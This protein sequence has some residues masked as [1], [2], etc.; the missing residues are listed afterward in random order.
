MRD[1]SEGIRHEHLDSVF[2]FRA[3]LEMLL[4]LIRDPPMCFEK[5]CNRTKQDNPLIYQSK[6]LNVNSDPS[7]DTR[8]LPSCAKCKIAKY[9]CKEHQE[10]DWIR[11]HK[12]TCTHLSALKQLL[13]LEQRPF[14]GHINFRF[15]VQN[16]T[17]TE[18]QQKS[19]TATLDFMLHHSTLPLSTFALSTP[20]ERLLSFMNDK[21]DWVV[22]A[23]SSLGVMAPL[24]DTF[25]GTSFS[26]SVVGRQL[27]ESVVRAKLKCQHSITDMLPRYEDEGREPLWLNLL[28]EA[29]IALETYESTLAWLPVWS[30]EAACPIHWYMQVDC[31]EYYRNIYDASPGWTVLD[32]DGQLLVRHSSGVIA[33]LHDEAVIL[34]QYVKLS[35]AQFPLL[36]LSPHINRGEQTEEIVHGSKDTPHL[37]TVWLR[38]DLVGSTYRRGARAVPDTVP[39]TLDAWG[40]SLPDI[41]KA[42]LDVDSFIESLSMGVQFGSLQVLGCDDDDINE[43]TGGSRGGGSASA[44]TKKK[45]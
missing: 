41:I 7:T 21:Q 29:S 2:V 16:E 1:M 17:A 8:V 12:K 39:M 13:G 27:K 25:F 15:E 14:E 5:P 26:D 10:S 9:Y 43:Q 33:C 36:M 40:E 28:R 3:S 44:Q 4:M 42:F 22:Q 38:A 18:K 45:T 6:K 37:M 11:G 24:A 19:D 31:P 20:L 32:S 35:K 23:R 34:A 30:C